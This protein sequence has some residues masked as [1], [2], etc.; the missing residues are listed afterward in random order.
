VAVGDDHGV[1]PAVLAAGGELEAKGLGDRR[2]AAAAAFLSLHLAI[3][4]TRPA[5][6]KKTANNGK[7]AR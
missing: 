4:T 2:A 3:V 7:L 6:G 5:R 1:D